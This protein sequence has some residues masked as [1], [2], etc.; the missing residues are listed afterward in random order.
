MAKR[1]QFVKKPE[2][3]HW[4]HMPPSFKKGR[5]DGFTLIELLVVIAIIAILASLLLPALANAKAKAKQTQCLSNFKQLQICYQMY[6]GDNAD[7]I[8]INLTSGGQATAA[9]T[10][11]W[12]AGDAQ[13]DTTTSN[14]M[15]GKLYSYNTQPA[16][17]ACPANNR[18]IATTSSPGHPASQVPQT[19]TCTIDFA[20][21]GGTPPG[22]PIS[23]GGL[24]FGSYQKSTQMHHPS[25]KF[26]FV[27]ENEFSVGDGCFGCYPAN[28]GV[29]IWWNLP[30]SR[31]SKG[32]IFSFG[33]GH[34]EYW[35]WHGTSVLTLRVPDGNQPG[36]SSDDVA[37]VIAD[38]SE[39]FPL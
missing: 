39:Y 15:Q 2:K 1:K 29:N 22:A 28:S 5:R 37:R 17:Y 3:F 33:D 6:V 12:I 7:K 30:G 34:A 18:M 25:R 27:D 26:V 8:P 24:T 4:D 16:I 14:I 21:G 20:L 19:R 35:K 36:D 10:E 13:T 23:A 38:G 31:H 11:S 9:T 32:C